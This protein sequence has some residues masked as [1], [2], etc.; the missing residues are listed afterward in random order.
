MFEVPQTEANYNLL[1]LFQFPIAPT[2]FVDCELSLGNAV[3]HSGACFVPYGA[4]TRFN[5]H[6]D[7]PAE[8][9][10]PIQFSCA[11]ALPLP[12]VQGLVCLTTIT[13][14]ARLMRW[15]AH[16][17]R[18]C[19][20]PPVLVWPPASCM[21]R[22]SECLLRIRVPICA[23]TCHRLWRALHAHGCCCTAQQA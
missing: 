17:Q 20:N 13:A 2:T 14:T 9:L 5:M 4:P 11:P 6:F 15:R 22:P 19:S 10:P 8:V 16:A 7:G 1:T 12:H 23:S 21:G 18:A 3:A